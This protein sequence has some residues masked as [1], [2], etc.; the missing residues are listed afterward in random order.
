MQVHVVDVSGDTAARR[1]QAKSTSNISKQEKGGKPARQNVKDLIRFAL[2]EK[3]V[4]SA[5]KCALILKWINRC[6]AFTGNA[7]YLLYASCDDFNNTVLDQ[8]QYIKIQPKTIDLAGL[9]FIYF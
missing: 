1:D 7:L 3:N 9:I 5:V 6:S 2:A 8:F 4:A